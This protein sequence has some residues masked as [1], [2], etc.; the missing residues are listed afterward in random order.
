V[1]ALNIA[2]T[3]LNFRGSLADCLNCVSQAVNAEMSVPRGHLRNKGG[4]LTDNFGKDRWPTAVRWLVSAREGDAMVR[5]PGAMAVT[6]H[7]GCGL[8]QTMNAR[9]I[10]CL[11]AVLFLFFTAAFGLAQTSSSNSLTSAVQS[12]YPQVE[13]LYIDLHEHPE[14]SLH[15]V[16]T[17][18]KLAS[19]LRQLGYE[20]TEHVGGNGVVAIL[21]NGSEP[22]IM[23][24][25]E[26]DAL[27]VPEKT[28]LAYASHVTTKDDEGHEVPV[29]HACGHD[30]HM[31][32]LVGTAEI[33]AKSRD[34]WRGTLMLIGQPAE[35]RVGGAKMML[36]DG[37]FTRF[38]KP[39]VGIALHTTNTIPAGEVGITPGYMSSNADTVN[40][41]I[42]GRG[43]HGAMPE[44][45]IDP[46]VIAAKTIVSLQTIVA[47]E[48]KPGDAAVITVGYIHGGTKNNIIPDEVRLGLTVRS[49]SPEVRRHLLAS[50]ERVTKAEAE[51]AGAPK[52]PLVEVGEGADAMYNDPKLSDQLAPVL[53]ETLGAANVVTLPPV[54]TSEDYSEYELA[55]VPSF[56]YQ[57]GVANPQQFAEAQAKGI[58]LPSNHSPFFAPDM[59]PSLKT[60]IESEVALLRSLMGAHPGHNAAGRAVTPS[61]PF[62][63]GHYRIR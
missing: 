22:V 50:I 19:Q 41:T 33:M 20:V 54:M 9:P 40:I 24:R 60:A 6:G 63:G 35:E 51:A 7:R 56:Y 58:S 2:G 4:G 26:L 52:A 1:T 45:T 61:Q 13:A 36:E 8:E 48:I 39:S 29:M 47:R 62:D 12:V 53:R 16:N 23:L 18:A 55:G 30:I 49:Y 34:Q 14:L 15:E 32:A 28:G 27:P 21:R 46:I 38:P 17:A 31:A 37:L 10:K 3:R 59:E 43:G 57:L 5:V 11:V 44:T 25:T 42:Y